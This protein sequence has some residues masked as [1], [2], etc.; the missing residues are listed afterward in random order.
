MSKKITNL[1]QGWRLIRLDQACRI[2]GG[3]TPKTDNPEFWDGNLAWTTPKDLSDLDSPYLEDSSRKITEAGLQSCGA[4][5]LPAGSVLFS[6]RAPIGLVA[7]NRIPM[8]T[9]QGFK[10]FIPHKESTDAKYL[11]HWLKANRSYLDSLGNGATF[12]EVSKAGVSRI[13]IPL[14]PIGLEA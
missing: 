11:Y 9:N 10:S 5:V 3:S 7:L 2:V 14:P 1:P 13:E 4:E 12:K 8:A 6:S